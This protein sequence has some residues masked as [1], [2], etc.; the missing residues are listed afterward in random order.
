[1]SRA[2]HVEFCKKSNQEV[3]NNKF[4]LKYKRDSKGNRTGVIISF[5]DNDGVVKVGW[6]KCNTKLES[7]DKHIG[8]HKAIECARMTNPHNI[9]HSIKRDLVEMQERALRYFRT[10]VVVQ[11]V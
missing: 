3:L 10:N 8:I 9:P 2:S 6:S 4:L 1:M 5:R 7:F 11:V